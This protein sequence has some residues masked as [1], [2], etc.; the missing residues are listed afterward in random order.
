VPLQPPHPPSRGHLQQQHQPSHK[1]TR[2]Q[3]AYVV[4]CLMLLHAPNPAH[5]STPT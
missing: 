3:V 4:H 5:A 2:M 1:H